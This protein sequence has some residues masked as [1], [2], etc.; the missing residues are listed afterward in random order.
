MD[1]RDVLRLGRALP[2]LFFWPGMLCPLR[3]RCRG[4]NSLP[5]WAGSTP[6]SEEAVVE[7][8]RAASRKPPI[9][10]RKTPFPRPTKTL[11]L[12]SV[13]RNP[14]QERSGAMEAR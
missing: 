7:E 14:F 5:H 13:S 1:R 6:F 2:R 3:A 4:S 10:H 11:E 8:A 12:R 9:R